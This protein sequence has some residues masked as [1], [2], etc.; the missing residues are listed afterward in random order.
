M[1]KFH[2]FYSWKKF[3]IANRPLLTI[4][5]SKKGMPTHTA[6]RLQ[7]WGTILLNCDFTMEYQP[8]KKLGYANGLSRLIPK[9]A[10]H[11][12]HSTKKGNGN[13]KTFCAM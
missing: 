7:C 2:K 12:H 11:S 8:F 9:N 1:K 4:Y 5:G 3:H 6:N 13:K 10:R